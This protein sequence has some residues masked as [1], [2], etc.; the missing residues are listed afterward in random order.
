VSHWVFCLGGGGG[1]RRGEG[2]LLNIRQL[3]RHQEDGTSLLSGWEHAT[4]AL[5]GHRRSGC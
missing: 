4:E 5:G 2:E 1:G 3:R